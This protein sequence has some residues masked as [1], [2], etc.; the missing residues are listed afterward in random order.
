MKEHYINIYPLMSDF[1]KIFDIPF[2][3]GFDTGIVAYHIENYSGQEITPKELYDEMVTCS[4]GV[5]G[6]THKLPEY[7]KEMNIQV[8][9]QKDNHFVVFQ[10]AP[11]LG[12]PNK[13][14]KKELKELKSFLEWI[15][16]EAILNPL[17]NVKLSFMR[18]GDKVDFNIISDSEIL[19]EELN[20]KMNEK[21][22]ASPILTQWLE[23]QKKGYKEVEKQCYDLW[24]SM[25]SFALMSLEEQMKI[26]KSR[27][28]KKEKHI[29]KHKRKN[30]F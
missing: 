4:F 29:F 14:W 25:H 26:I 11:F 23:T 6:V 7:V 9:E 3:N 18:V 20:K 21:V 27:P 17:H 22:A 15:K 19:E 12:L 24:I 5:F 1:L 28:E 13:D 30:R 16:E 2:K 8:V 10:L